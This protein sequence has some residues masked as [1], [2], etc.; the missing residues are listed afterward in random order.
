MLFVQFWTI[1]NVSILQNMNSLQSIGALLCAD[2]SSLIIR[3]KH[4]KSNINLL[5]L[6][7]IT[8][9]LGRCTLVYLIGLYFIKHSIVVQIKSKPHEMS[10]KINNF[11][12]LKNHLHQSG[13][14]DLGHFI[15]IFR[16]HRSISGQPDPFSMWTL[17][18]NNSEIFS[19]I[20][21]AQSFK[22]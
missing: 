17:Q 1:L 19:F 9:T 14:Q 7:K 4:V 18:T 12:K 15:Y 6:S 2:T 16:L 8:F 11:W 3:P 20:K 22:I 13:K 21:L 5:S 10:L